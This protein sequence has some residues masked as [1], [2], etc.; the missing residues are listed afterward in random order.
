MET[1]CPKCGRDARIL[2]YFGVYLI[3]C[4]NCGY[5][6]SSQYDIVAD[7]RKSQREKTK[8]SPYKIGG[9]QRSR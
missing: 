7:Q 8:H 1:K 4:G 9:K 3:R 6:E 2:M 5:D